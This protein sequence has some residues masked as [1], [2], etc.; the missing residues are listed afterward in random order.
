MKFL[1]RYILILLITL[2]SLPSLAQEVPAQDTTASQMDKETV[3]LI[4]KMF[5]GQEISLIKS[6]ADQLIASGT[7]PQEQALI[8]SY[9]FDYYQQSKYMGYEEIALYIAD[10]YFLNKKL[11]FGHKNTP[12]FKL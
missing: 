4:M 2:F 8:A 11:I 10:N 1:E 12:N 6:K 7:D 3:H 9:I 5:D